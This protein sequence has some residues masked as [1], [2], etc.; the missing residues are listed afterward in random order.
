MVKIFR[1]WNRRLQRFVN[2]AD[3]MN[4]LATIECA[5]RTVGGAQMTTSEFA[6]RSF[7]AQFLAD[8]NGHAP[9]WPSGEITR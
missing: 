6:L 4:D 5:A 9:E 8:A 7:C 1:P 2:H 3:E